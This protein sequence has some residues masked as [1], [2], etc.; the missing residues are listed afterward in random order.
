M[1]KM[2]KLIQVHPSLSSTIAC[3]MGKEQKGVGSVTPSPSSF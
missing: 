3:Y 1:E 2:M